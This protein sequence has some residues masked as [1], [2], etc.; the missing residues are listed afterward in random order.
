M[1]QK[2]F[3]IDFSII[4]FLAL[5]L[6]GVGFS[7]GNSRIGEYNPPWTRYQILAAPKEIAEIS[8]VEIKSNLLDPSGD[9]LYVTSE[10][11]ES[12]S[13]YL[14]E[15]EWSVVYSPPTWN[16]SLSKCG[17]ERL[18]PTKSHMWDVPPVEKRVID[19]AGVYFDRPVS[20]IVRCYVLL[21]DGSLEVWVHS[22]N[23]MDSLAVEFLK[24]LYVIV[25]VIFGIIIG[26]II[27][28]YRKRVSR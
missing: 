22:G 23:A 8:F 25:G 20:I 5:L 28:R 14:F 4:G 6:G 1:K 27:I 19:S 16:N 11:G 2:S 12:F 3:L 10:D 17:A 15:A 7:V 21:D 13:N 24:I 18:G 26:V 9:V